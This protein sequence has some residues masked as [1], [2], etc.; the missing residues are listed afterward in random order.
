MAAVLL[1]CS[2]SCEKNPQPQPVAGNVSVSPEQIMADYAKSTKEIT[3]TADC[4]WGIAA[5]DK[6][7]CTVS[8]S[9]GGKGETV[10][11]VTISENTTLA[12]RE[13]EL[14]VRFGSHKVSVPVRQNYKVEGVTV[15]DPAFQKALIDG[16]DADGD[17]ILSTVEAAAITSIQA[18]NYGIVDMSELC[19]LFPGLTSLS[20]AGNKLTS[21]NISTLYKLAKLDCTGN[22][23]LKSIYVWSGFKAPAGFSKPDYAQYIE[24]EIPTPNGY[25]LVWQDEFSGSQV[26]NSKWTFENWDPGHVNNEL[27][28]YVSG[29]VLDG[30][31]TAFIEDGALNIRAMKYNGQVISARM[32]STG[33]WLYGYMEAKIQLPVG[34]GTWPAFW[35][36]PNDFSK[37]WPKCG[38]IDIME[39]VGANPN[40]TSSS[41][42]CMA[43]YHKINT[44]KTREVYTKGAESEYHVYACEW[45]EDYIKSYRD[46]ELFFT[47]ENDKTGNEDTWPFNKTFYII[48][49]LAWGGDWGGYR[50]VDE[51]ALPCTM[52]VDY[53][54]VFQK[55][56]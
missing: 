23:D 18:D 6:S 26:D 22:P 25:K 44:Q 13:N 2:A 43:Y 31:R 21:L 16:H 8:P 49:N 11:R 3:V 34:K 14:V 52:K 10:V 45:T 7:W 47:F 9:G 28:R 50:G 40:Y 27:Q 29:G 46:G 33:K 42:H 53:V 41:I 48:L 15:A 36:M 37:G 38:E 12:V 20:C 55:V 5:S 17:G 54:R 39:E 35:M 24:P 51:T 30:N 4:E 32:N 19:D 56:K 1:L